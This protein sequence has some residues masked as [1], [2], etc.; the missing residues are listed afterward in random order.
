MGVVLGRTTSSFI[1]LHRAFATRAV[2]H[3]CL[4]QFF[5]ANLDPLADLVLDV[6]SLLGG[7]FVSPQSVRGKDSC[8]E[9]DI[10]N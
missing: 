7:V 2:R 8:I 10:K 6:A 4:K 5:A 1:L 3:L 9:S